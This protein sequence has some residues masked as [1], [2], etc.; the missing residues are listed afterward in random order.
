VFITDVHYEVMQEN[1]PFYS[2]DLDRNAPAEERREVA[3]VIELLQSP[4]LQEHINA[5]RVTFAMIRP[6]VGPEDN[7][8]GLSDEAAAWEI[9]SM[10]EGLGVMAKFS[11]TFTP[12]D[13]DVFY[14]GT[15]VETMQNGPTMRDFSFPNRWEEFRVQ[16]ASGPVTA[17]LLFDSE[18]QAVEKWRDHLGHWNIDKYRDPATIR[19]KLG[20]DKYNNLVHGS[21][22][23]ESVQKELQLVAGILQRELSRPS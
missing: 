16:M 20:I 2:P 22:S 15:P 21:D 18:G 5:G 11:F 14:T 9:E 8:L 17:L 19:G 13:T 6:H 7:L 12:E 1:F 4:E 3:A 10:I 23:P